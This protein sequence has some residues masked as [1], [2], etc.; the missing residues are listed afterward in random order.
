MN[1]KLN[2]TKGL[3]LHIAGKAVDSPADAMPVEP[4]SVA[5]VPD[6][7]PGLILKP[8]VKEGDAVVQGDTVLIDKHNTDISLTSPV[9]GIVKAIVRG[10]R[11]KLERI[12]L[13]PSPNNNSQC[14]IFEIPSKLTAETA[15]HILQQSGLWAMI[16]QRPYN[17]VA[18]CG[19]LP[20]D[21]FVNAIDTAPLAPDIDSILSSRTNEL[22]AGV[23]LLSAIT[24]GTI[25]IGRRA[26]GSIPDIPGA[27]MV[28]INGPHPAGNPGVMA[29]NIKPV[30]KGETIWTL[31]GVTLARI[32]HL[33]LT[34]K[35]DY[36]CLVAITGSEVESTG[37]ISTTIG[38]DI[39]SLLHQR[40]KAENHHTR[41]ISGN[42][43]SG[44][45]VESD[46]YL[47]FPYTQ[48]TV[49]PEGDDIVEFMGWATLSPNKMSTS[50]SF[51]GHFLL[52]KLFKPDARLLGG[53]R[54]MIMSGQYDEVVPMDIM[55]EYLI[56][57]ILSHDIEKME[58]LGIYEVA[59]EDFSV[60]EYVCTSKL[61]LQE[62]VAQGLDYLHKELE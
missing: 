26:D 16:R 44:I 8:V 30:N 13:E 60:A 28:D 38:C 40:L 61:P 9:T 17:I 21:I 7:F 11:R 23:R 29:A 33:A 58:Q 6:D 56:K 46:G 42:V 52:K 24:E 25:Y 62:I 47:R 48:L 43:L 45:K 35:V 51:P 34:G 4:L 10:E 22:E 54:A 19:S 2:I 5:I 3:D 53:R 14:R 27:T 1:I 18:S 36:K 32:G 50:R 41:I 15:R 31:D 59:P 55:T 49:I 37:Y 39:H 20:R 57:A 12:V